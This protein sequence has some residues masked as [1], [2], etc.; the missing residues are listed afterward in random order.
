MYFI[1]AQD[2]TSAITA[3]NTAIDGLSAFGWGRT[4]LAR[5]MSDYADLAYLAAAD[6]Y[7]HLWVYT[8]GYENT[9]LHNS[10]SA[11]CGHCD[12]HLASPPDINHNTYDPNCEWFPYCDPAII[13][14]CSDY[15]MCMAAAF[16]THGIVDV[17]HFGWGHIPKQRDAIDG[18]LQ[19]ERPAT[20]EVWP[21]EDFAWLKYVAEESGGLFSLVRDDPIPDVTIEK[22]H[23]TIQGQHEFVSVTFASGMYE[24]GGF[25]FLI[26]YDAS[27]LTF[28]EATSGQLLEDCGW[29]YFTYRYGPFG[30][31]GDACPSGLLRIIAVADMNNGPN[32]PSCFGPPEFD[33]DPYEVA[34]LKFLVTD[35]RTFECTYVPIRFFWMDCG[36][37]TISSKSG[38]TLFVSDHVYDFEGTE[39]TDPTYG[40]PTYFG[41]Q[42]ECFDSSL[43]YIDAE[44]G[45][46][47]YKVPLPLI[48]FHNGGI[49][50]VCAESLDV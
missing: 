18:G 1:Y 16:I 11:V 5:A 50:I 29:E 9:S 38:D 35:D 12:V 33:Y 20:K 39:V 45:D 40:F 42:K 43:W 4:P 22:T 27:A 19:G 8:D 3:V 34:E 14:S 44:T 2:F 32:H 25:D 30:N 10:T 6:G 37:N 17:R 41:I 24:M 28:M 36:D 21:P 46:T 31:C 7:R 26:A 48:A 15:Q 47:V 13:G 23:N 49:D